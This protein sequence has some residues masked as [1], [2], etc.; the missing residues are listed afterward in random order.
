[1]AESALRPKPN[2]TLADLPGGVRLRRSRFRPRAR[3]RALDLGTRRGLRSLLAENYGRQ[4]QES[5]ADQ[6]G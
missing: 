1:M 6:Y 2:L 4:R 3:S 5:T